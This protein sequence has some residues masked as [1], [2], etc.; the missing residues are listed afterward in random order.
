M[1][2]ERDAPSTSA[3]TGLAYINATQYF[4]GIPQ[5]T[6]S[7]L[8]IK[9]QKSAIANPCVWS[10]RVG[11]YQVCEKWLKDRKGLTLDYADLQ[12]YQK[13]VV[14]LHATIRLMV[15]IDQ[16]IASY[17]GWPIAFGGGG[18]EVLA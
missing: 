11:G 13:I 5:A 6:V 4:G 9:N 3:A 16:T 7:A 8:P 14:A 12:H 2:G 10:F 15:T 18:Q 17:V 1:W